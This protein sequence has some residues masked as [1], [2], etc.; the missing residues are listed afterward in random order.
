[1]RDNVVIED[2]TIVS[3]V[4]D[5]KFTAE[6]PCLQ[7]QAEALKTVNTGCGACARRRQEAQRQAFSNIKTC[8]AGMD[9][10]H[11][12]KLK[13]LL[14]TQQVKLVFVSATGQVSSITF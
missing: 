5:E 11:K 3:M 7:N 14:D 12:A 10:A 1:M 2:A 8:L 13:E 9:V 4:A 6:I